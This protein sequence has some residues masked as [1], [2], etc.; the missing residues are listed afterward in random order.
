M[1]PF[2]YIEGFFAIDVTYSYIFY[3][4]I[5]GVPDNPKLRFFTK[6]QQTRHSFF[7]K[8]MA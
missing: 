2:T 6:I 1:F 7:L 8:S 4:S 5:P 3:F